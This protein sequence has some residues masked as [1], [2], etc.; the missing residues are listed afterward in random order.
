[1][2]GLDLS[3]RMQ[4]AVDRLLDRLSE[5]GQQIHEHQ[6]GVVDLRQA[7]ERAERSVDELSARCDD[8]EQQLKHETE[9]REYLS[10][11]FYKADG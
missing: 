3:G 11:E 4:R 7:L 6:Q 9:T 2:H 1:L 10:L 8:L 5:A